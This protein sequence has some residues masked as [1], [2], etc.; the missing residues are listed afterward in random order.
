MKPWSIGFALLAFLMIGAV[1]P[2]W[3]Y[4]VTSSPGV[5]GLSMESQ[6]LASFALPAVLLLFLGGWLAP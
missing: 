2:V 5:Q 6:F 1:A 4:F 3:Y